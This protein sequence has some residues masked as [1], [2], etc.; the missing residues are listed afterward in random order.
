MFP[1]SF[2]IVFL[3][4]FEAI[5]QMERFKVSIHINY[6]T[7]SFCLPRLVNE[8]QNRTFI[9]DW[10][11]TFF[12]PPFFIIVVMFKKTHF[13]DTPITF[14]H[15][16]TWIYTVVLKYITT[17]TKKRIQGHFVL[18]LSQTSQPNRYITIK[19]YVLSNQWIKQKKINNTWSDL[20]F[21][22]ISL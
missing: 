15:T 14:K 18:Q 12:C 19:R 11:T 16:H 17:F 9:Q 2:L 8:K 7:S 3:F 21:V 20:N 6:S 5:K 22:T 4:L 13:N 10:L 1:F